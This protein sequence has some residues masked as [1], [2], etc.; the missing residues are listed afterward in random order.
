MR[1]FVDVRSRGSLRAQRRREGRRLPLRTDH[2]R[3]DG[4]TIHLYYGAADFC[5]AMAT[6]SVRPLLTWLGAHPSVDRR[7]GL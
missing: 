1:L 2:R 5:V 3:A 7:S 4:D 6:G